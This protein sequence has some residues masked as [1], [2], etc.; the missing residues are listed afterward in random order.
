MM[1][2]LSVSLI[3]LLIFPPSFMCVS[4]SFSPKIA[5]I[6]RE[7]S[8]R[9]IRE[10]EDIGQMRV[11]PVRVKGTGS[12]LKQF[13]WL[14]RSQDISRPLV[15]LLTS[16]PPVG[17]GALVASPQPSSMLWVP[18]FFS[19][20]FRFIAV[21]FIVFVFHVS[22]LPFYFLFFFPLFRGIST[23]PA[24]SGRS[25]LTLRPNLPAST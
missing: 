24:L 18:L 21:Q 14:P 16:Y 13:W 6:R 2:I 17:S 3:L 8:K 7:T 19:S 12:F 1:G 5:I 23:V 10:D 11:S 4:F 20:F 9:T 15:N 25:S 22:I